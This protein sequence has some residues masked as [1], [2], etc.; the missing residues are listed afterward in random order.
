MNNAVTYYQT[1]EE[2]AWLFR[3]EKPKKWHKISKNLKNLEVLQ[4]ILNFVIFKRWK[5]IHDQ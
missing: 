2:A 4:K 5:L 1:L 3:L